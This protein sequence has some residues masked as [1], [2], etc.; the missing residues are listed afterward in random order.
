MS[1]R[2][3]LISSTSILLV[4][5]AGVAAALAHVGFK[6]GDDWQRTMLAKLD[7]LLAQR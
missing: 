1:P 2:S 3:L 5:L 7:E 6:R 4:S